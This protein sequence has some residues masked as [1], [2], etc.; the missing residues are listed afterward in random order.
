MF[1]S[2]C[3]CHVSYFRTRQ[4][5]FDFRSAI[6]LLVALK[7]SNK[8]KHNIWLF[9]LKTWSILF[10]TCSID[11]SFVAMTINVAFQ[12][13]RFLMWHVVL[14]SPYQLCNVYKIIPMRLCTNKLPPRVQAMPI[15]TL[16]LWQAQVKNIPLKNTHNICHPRPVPVHVCVSVIFCVS[17]TVGDIPT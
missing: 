2:V 12:F 9:I 4:Y 16:T 7:I 6:Q 10:K 15:S 3:T 13:Q 8:I 1:E 14:F 5:L 17:S 11:I